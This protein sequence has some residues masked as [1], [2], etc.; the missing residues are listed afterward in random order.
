M[1]KT[2]SFELPIYT[3]QIDFVGHVSNIVYVQWMEIGRH[4][5][6]ED[7]EL[8]IERIAREGI[9]PVLIHTEIDYLDPLFLGDQ[10]HVEMWL[11]ELRHA[12]ARIEFR[13][14]RIATRWPLPALS[15]GCSSTGRR[16]APTGCPLK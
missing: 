14:T 11:S 10:G 4:R 2:V 5:L 15:A 8:P 7:M 1:M 3:Y 13:F 9:V 16:C 6:L 12:S